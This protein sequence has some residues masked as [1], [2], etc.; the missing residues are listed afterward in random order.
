M[1]YSHNSFHSLSL[2]WKVFNISFKCAWLPS[3]NDGR[4]MFRIQSLMQTVSGLIL[5]ERWVLSILM[6]LLKRWHMIVDGAL[7]KVS[8][9]CLVSCEALDHER[10]SEVILVVRLLVQPWFPLF[11]LFCPSGFFFS[12]QDNFL[13]ADLFKSMTSFQNSFEASQ[14]FYQTAGEFSNIPY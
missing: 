1:I 10:Q 13:C 5:R 4:N 11:Y 7:S 2:G 6:D 12:S 9:L 3:L 8:F 14:V